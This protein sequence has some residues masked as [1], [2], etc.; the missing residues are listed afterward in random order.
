MDY[1]KKY[2]EAL[3]NFKKIKSANKDNKELVDFIEY[4]YP[5]IKESEDE[6]V[7]KWLIDWA[8]T[9]HWSEQFSVTNEQVLAWLEKQGQGEQKP[10]WSEE[11]EKRVESLHGWLDTLVLYIHYD[12]T[13]PLDLRRERIQQVERLKTWLKSLKD[14][15]TWK[16]SDEQ[17]DA[18]KTYIYNP[19]YF[20]SPDPRME[21]VV[22]V[23]NELKKL[24]EE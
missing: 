15:Y 5:E 18:L 20:N 1:K 10:A 23:Y 4:E 17:M 16:P 11:D 8:N 14:R 3:D 21:L 22:S 12:A 6:K 7:R 19:M 24:K 2:E 9:V 13:V